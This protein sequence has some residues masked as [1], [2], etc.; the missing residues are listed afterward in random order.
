MGEE[1][2][3]KEPTE[4]SYADVAESGTSDVPDDGLSI[5]RLSGGVMKPA[6]AKTAN[7]IDGLLAKMIAQPVS[8]LYVENIDKNLDFLFTSLQL[9]MINIAAEGSSER[10]QVQAPIREQPVVQEVKLELGAPF[11]DDGREV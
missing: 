5:F 1:K 9:D 2:R 10:P 11:H 3:V 6:A 4:Y 7:R 8:G